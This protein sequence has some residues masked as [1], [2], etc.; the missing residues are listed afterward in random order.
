ME[1]TKGKVVM[2]GIACKLSRFGQYP[3]IITP[4]PPFSVTSLLSWQ[5][6]ELS[7][8]KQK[9]TKTGQA[10]SSELT[11]HIGQKTLQSIP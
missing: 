1:E 10:D 2:G 11:K 7:I 3:P 6:L 5:R 9:Q 8:K 4:L